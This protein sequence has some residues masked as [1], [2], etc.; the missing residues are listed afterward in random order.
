MGALRV[1]WGLTDQSGIECVRLTEEAWKLRFAR[2][3]FP[4]KVPLPNVQPKRVEVPA[5]LRRLWEGEN[6][7][8]PPPLPL[9]LPTRTYYEEDD[10]WTQEPWMQLPP[11][12]VS[13]NSEGEASESEQKS[14]G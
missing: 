3:A 10:N 8:A 6:A 4:A 5:E 2:K 9:R 7:P 12:S 11:D 13:D 14:E 1:R